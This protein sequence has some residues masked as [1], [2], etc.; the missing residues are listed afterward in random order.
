MGQWVTD[1]IMTRLQRGIAKK[2]IIRM[3]ITSSENFFFFI[4]I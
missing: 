2:S 4:L 1:S 3:I